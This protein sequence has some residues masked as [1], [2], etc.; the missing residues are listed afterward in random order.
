[1]TVTSLESGQDAIYGVLL[2]YTKV[3]FHRE[4]SETRRNLGRR[5]ATSVATF[6]KNKNMF[7]N[8]NEMNGE[9]VK[10]RKLFIN[11]LQ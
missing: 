2:N 7:V 11:G 6:T 4:K 3:F 10:G 5:R 8:I 9:V 1:M